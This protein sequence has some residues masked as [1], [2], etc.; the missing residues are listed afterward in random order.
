MQSLICPTEGSAPS[1][2][3]PLNLAER[4]P[5]TFMYNLH[6]Y[7]LHNRWGQ[8][9]K[10]NEMWGRLRWQRNSWVPLKKTKTWESTTCLMEI[11]RCHST[12][13]RVTAGF[14]NTFHYF[15]L[16]LGW[17]LSKSKEDWCSSLVTWSIIYPT[18]RYPETGTG[19]H[20]SRQ[21]VLLYTSSPGKFAGSLSIFVIK[22]HSGKQPQDNTG[23]ETTLLLLAVSIS[24]L[25][26]F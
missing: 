14:F 12:H 4:N 20:T 15:H 11:M 6:T 17:D 25:A 13:E 23:Q 21:E 26:T 9:S 19:S 24:V 16:T 8:N 10:I 3:T 5:L 1:S 22:V 7:T 18:C 2:L